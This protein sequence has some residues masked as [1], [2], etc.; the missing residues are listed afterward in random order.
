M[1]EAEFDSL[2]IKMLLQDLKGLRPE[3]LLKGELAPFAL[4]VGKQIGRYPPDFPGNTY[5]R[6][7]HLS[8]NWYYELIDPLAIELGNLARYA[9]WV[10]GPKQV[11]LHA[12]HGW[13]RLF[14]EAPKYVAAFLR[15]IATKAG[16]KW[17]A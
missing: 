7:Q 15:K 6:T 16:R 2:E 10:H 8:R 3:N 12:G 14:E 11:S 4:A 1:I 13:K 17:R 5:R 9:G